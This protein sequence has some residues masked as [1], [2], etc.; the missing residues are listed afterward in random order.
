MS[1]SR[2]IIESILEARSRRKIDLAKTLRVLQGWEYSPLQGILY[3]LTSTLRVRCSGKFYMKEVEEL[4]KGIECQVEGRFIISNETPNT[5]LPFHKV[6]MRIVDLI[7]ELLKV[8]EF[9]VQHNSKLEAIR[10][11]TGERLGWRND[12]TKFTFTEDADKTFGI[13]EI[14]AVFNADYPRITNQ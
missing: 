8:A 9:S 5:P 13:L 6:K 1:T 4:G 3:P 7:I 2:Q 10:D 11:I 12:S 14:G